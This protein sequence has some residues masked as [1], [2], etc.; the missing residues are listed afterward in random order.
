MQQ[1]QWSSFQ[2]I[3]MAESRRPHGCLTLHLYVGASA[4]WP[5][6]L[7]K[8]PRGAAIMKDEPVLSLQSSAVCIHVCPFQTAFCLRLKQGQFLPGGSLPPLKQTPSGGFLML[9]IFEVEMRILPR[10]DLSQCQKRLKLI[11]HFKMPYSVSLCGVWGPS[12]YI[13]HV[14]RQALFLNTCYLFNLGSNFVINYSGNMTVVFDWL[15][16]CIT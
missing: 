3:K 7:D 11:K 5:R 16:L 8:V 9:I 12:I 2:T 6:I 15:L 1:V 10:A 4:F 14:N 13:A